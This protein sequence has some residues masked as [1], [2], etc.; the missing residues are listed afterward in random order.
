MAGIVFCRTRNE[1]DALA[2]RLAMDLRLKE[3]TGSVFAYHAGKSDST[4]RQ[5][6]NTWTSSAGKA[7][8]DICCATISF[9]MGIDRPDVDFVVHF[10]LPQSISAYHQA[11]GRLL[12][13]QTPL[14]IWKGG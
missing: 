5:L 10:T 9:G 7:R 13:T 8:L 4:R 1:C 2:A 11:F 12:L 6:S 3:P 14:G